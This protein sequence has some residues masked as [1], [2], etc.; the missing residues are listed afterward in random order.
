[1]TLANCFL[2]TCW[3]HCRNGRND[4]W[5]G[6]AE[7]TNSDVIGVDN[8]CETSVLDEC[9]AFKVGPCYALWVKGKSPLSHV[10]VAIK[11]NIKLFQ[12]V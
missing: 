4:A 8:Q 12:E 1:M 3:A 6:A 11:K 5:L 7:Q 9:H 10:K 2:V